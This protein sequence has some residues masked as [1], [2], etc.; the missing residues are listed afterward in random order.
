MA[1]HAFSV[2]VGFDPPGP[3]LA[4]LSLISVVLGIDP[5]N[6]N[7]AFLFAVCASRSGACW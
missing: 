4:E 5:Q 1:L 6:R 7:V 3:S 2:I